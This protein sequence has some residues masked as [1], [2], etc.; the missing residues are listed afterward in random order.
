MASWLGEPVLPL[1]SGGSFSQV[2]VAFYG[3]LLL[4]NVPRGMA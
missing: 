2:G 1:V 3:H 4:K